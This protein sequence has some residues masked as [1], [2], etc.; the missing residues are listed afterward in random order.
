[1]QSLIP[2]VTKTCHVAYFKYPEVVSACTILRYERYLSIV[3]CSIGLIACFTSANT[4]RSHYSVFLRLFLHRV[5]VLQMFVPRTD[6]LL[7]K[8]L[9]SSDLHV[10]NAYV[11]VRMSA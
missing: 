2:A 5:G 10:A 3:F 4:I 7:C 11:Y 1:M 8:N 6:R 9:E